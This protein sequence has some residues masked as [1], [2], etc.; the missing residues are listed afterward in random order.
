MTPVVLLLDILMVL[1]SQL[2]GLSQTAF[3]HGDA[4]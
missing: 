4:E 1:I 3:N 2:T